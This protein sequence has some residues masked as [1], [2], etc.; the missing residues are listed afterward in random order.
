MLH[1]QVEFPVPGA[2]NAARK[3]PLQH[4]W[5]MFAGVAHPKS[6]GALLLTGPN[7]ND[8]VIIRANV[9]SHPDDVTAAIPSVELCRELGNSNAF[10]RL[11]K[12]EHMPG[13]LNQAEMEQYARN[14]AVTYWHQTCT[15]KMGRDAMSVVDAKLQVY[16]IEGVRI[17]DGSIMPQIMTG[18][19]MA[20][21]VVIGE[22]AADIL[23]ARYSV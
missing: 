10:N 16:G 21:R 12:G 22:R 17:A 2:E 3:A 7:P 18:N 20:P 6:R 15:A 23:R 5:T 19:T 13:Q 14:A 11:V 9:L 1:C 8:P 4:G